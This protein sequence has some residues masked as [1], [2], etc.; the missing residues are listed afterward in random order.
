MGGREWGSLCAESRWHQGRW[1]WM[2]RPQCLLGCWSVHLSFPKSKSVPLTPAL[3]NLT[4]L[5]SLMS[6]FPSRCEFGG[7]AVH[8]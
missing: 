3:S 4:A 1:K 8:G 2:W 5:W 6:P 7:Q